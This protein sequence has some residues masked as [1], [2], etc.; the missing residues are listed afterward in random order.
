MKYQI[1]QQ[2]N[3]LEAGIRYC[4]TQIKLTT[5]NWVKKEYQSV[6]EDYEL[7]ILHL[8]ARLEFITSKAA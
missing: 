6:I 8:K 5:E 1:I 3:E 7:Q 4:T 2:I